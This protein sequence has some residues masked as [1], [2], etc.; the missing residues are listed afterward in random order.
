MQVNSLNRS[1]TKLQEETG[2]LKQPNHQ[3]RQTHRPVMSR[4][5]TGSDCQ[6]AAAVATL[7]RQVTDNTGIIDH[8][9]PIAKRGK[10]Q[11]GDHRDQPACGTPP[12]RQSDEGGEDLTHVALSRAGP[13][14]MSGPRGAHPTTD[15]PMVGKTST[16]RRIFNCTPF[17][18]RGWRKGCH[19]NPQGPGSTPCPE[20]RN[21]GFARQGRG[22]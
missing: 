20:D 5:I 8:Y 18:S 6:G 16:P 11:V 14:S 2:S 9:P 13:P 3:R 19:T 21:P 7:S 10:L 22:N 15:Y 17:T 12:D 4:A 1:R